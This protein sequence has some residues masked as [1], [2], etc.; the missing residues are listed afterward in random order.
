MGH[1]IH[2]HAKKAYKK[3]KDPKVSFWHKA[4]EIAM[5]AAI[6]VFAVSVSIWFHNMSETRHK[7]TMLKSLCWD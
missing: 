7:G 4:K 5:E 3:W 2:D 6:I 1:E